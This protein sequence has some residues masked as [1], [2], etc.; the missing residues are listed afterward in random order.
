MAG[1]NRDVAA[2]TVG[3]NGAFYCAFLLGSHCSAS[4]CVLFLRPARLATG[5][6]SPNVSLQQTGDWRTLASLAMIDSPAGELWR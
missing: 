3:S 5:A 6:G 1:D 4:A 2:S